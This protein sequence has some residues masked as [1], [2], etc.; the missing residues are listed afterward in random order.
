MS[1]IFLSRKI[2]I[3]GK[4]Q[5]V[6]EKNVRYVENLIKDTGEPLEAAIERIIIEYHEQKRQ[7]LEEE[8]IKAQAQERGSLDY[9]IHVYPTQRSKP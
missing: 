9:Y 7:Q 2:I 1:L 8:R 6:Q 5:E 3:N 4:V